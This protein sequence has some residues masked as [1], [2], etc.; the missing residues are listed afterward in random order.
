MA[1]MNHAAG[2]RRH[3]ERQGF[4]LVEDRFDQPGFGLWQQQ[5]RPKVCLY[6]P[7]SQAFGDDEW[8]LADFRFLPARVVMA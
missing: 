5:A 2:V 1:S 7:V 6:R 4:A 3:L 8:R